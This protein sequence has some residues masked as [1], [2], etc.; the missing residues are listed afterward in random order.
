MGKKMSS[1]QKSWTGAVQKRIAMTA[2]ML[3]S[4]KSLKIMGMS[5]FIQTSIQTQ[6][7]Q[8]LDL[9]KK[10]RWIV[11]VLNMIGEWPQN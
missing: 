4:I 5:D 9:S 2:S 11:V 3:A 6:R 1:K 7:L 10:F 8:E